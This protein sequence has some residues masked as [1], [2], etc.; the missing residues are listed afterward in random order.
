MVKMSGIPA[1][2]ILNMKAGPT[3][4]GRFRTIG[5]YLQVVRGERV[6]G[7]PETSVR[8]EYLVVLLE[9]DA[10]GASIHST[11]FDSVDFQDLRVTI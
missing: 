9:Y 1:M 7:L 6:S 2:G 4:I 10:A 3:A 8:Y 11:G 5:E